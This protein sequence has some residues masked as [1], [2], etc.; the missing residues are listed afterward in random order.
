MAAEGRTWRRGSARTLRSVNGAAAGW[1]RKAAARNMA[2]D[3]GPERQWGRGRMA[4]EGARA[5][6]YS[7]TA[8]GVN[9]AAAGWPRKACR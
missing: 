5:R 4:A 9:G 3:L 6:S 1:P 8:R 7:A 2:Y